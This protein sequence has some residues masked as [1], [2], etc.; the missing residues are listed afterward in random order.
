MTFFRPKTRKCPLLAWS[1][2]CCAPLFFHSDWCIFCIEN[3]KNTFISFDNKQ[4]ILDRW[5]FLLSQAQSQA[6]VELYEKEKQKNEE[7][8]NQVTILMC[9]EISVTNIDN[10]QNFV[11]AAVIF[12]LVQIPFRVDILVGGPDL[13]KSNHEK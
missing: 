5:S 4:I 10:L 8:Q 2:Y 11:C 6:K 7:S 12:Y 13:K 9:N 1:F 3:Y